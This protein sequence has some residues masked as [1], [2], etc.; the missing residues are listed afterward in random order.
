V[1]IYGASCTINGFLSTQKNKG[2]SGSAAWS[3]PRDGVPRL[4][5]AQDFDVLVAPATAR[6]LRA[7]GGKQ[8]AEP[9]AK[10]KVPPKIRHRG[11]FL[12]CP[13]RL[14]LPFKRFLNGHRPGAPS[15]PPPLALAPHGVRSTSSSGP[16]GLVWGYSRVNGLSKLHHFVKS[17]KSGGSVIRH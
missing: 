5:R 14:R 17:S 7:K 15:P 11:G 2:I 12:S 13:L 1:I 9:L 4:S 3:G 16:G 6:R 10:A 8:R